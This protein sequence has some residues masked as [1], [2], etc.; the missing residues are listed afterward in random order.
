MA[1]KEGGSWACRLLSKRETEW[2]KAQGSHKTQ[3]PSPSYRASP[4]PLP[5]SGDTKLLLKQR[6]L[7]SREAYR[8]S[9]SSHRC[10]KRTGPLS[11]VT[12]QRRFF[13]LPVYHHSC[14]VFCNERQLPSRLHCCQEKDPEDVLGHL[15]RARP[16]PQSEK[17]IQPRQW[18]LQ[19]VSSGTLPVCSFACESSLYSSA[20]GSR[21]LFRQIPKFL[22]SNHLPPVF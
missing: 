19:R 15:L 1:N 16:A 5:I 10:R 20:Q 6:Y 2:G 11:P 14:V 4:P 7:K 12:E 21:G 17:T 13:S 22:P 18:V 9:Q 3:P 8:Q